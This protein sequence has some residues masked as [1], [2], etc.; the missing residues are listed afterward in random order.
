MNITVINPPCFQEIVIIGNISYQDKMYIQDILNTM[1]Y[2]EYAGYSPDEQKK[3]KDIKTILTS[4]SKANVI[5]ITKT[6][7]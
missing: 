3:Y 7:R 5:S 4:Y 2:D 1:S 6:G